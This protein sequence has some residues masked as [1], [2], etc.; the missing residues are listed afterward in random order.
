MITEQDDIIVLP[1][2]YRLNEKLLDA[3][4]GNNI[5]TDISQRGHIIKG[6]KG[7]DIITVKAGN[8]ILFDGEGNDALYVGDGADILITTGGN[9]TL[10]VG[11]GNNIIFIN[12]LNGHIK[13]INS[14]GK[15]TII[16]QDKKIADYQIVD[17]NGNRSYFSSDSLSGILIE[18]YEQ[19]NITVKAR[20]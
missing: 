16:L 5:V 4:D 13:I 2:D 1:L 6:G 15:D 12:Q 18:D 20:I 17:H 8:N 19:Q 10:T 7:N 14:G 11:K 9:V 3:G